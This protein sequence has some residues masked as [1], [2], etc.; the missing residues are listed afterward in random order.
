M[1]STQLF[2]LLLKDN[3]WS[4]HPWKPA[5][6]PS[7]MFPPSA[8]S[9]LSS[10]KHEELLS[11]SPQDT[12]LSKIQEE[13]LFSWVELLGLTG[14]FFTATVGSLRYLRTKTLSVYI[15]GAL[16]KCLLSS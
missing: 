12:N 15:G 13:I 8:S 4:P 7:W 11:P 2:G 14:V 3:A 10:S 16:Q 1:G 9:E 5:C 6:T